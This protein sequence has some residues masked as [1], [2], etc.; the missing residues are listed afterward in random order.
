MATP[1]DLVTLAMLKAW[2]NIPAAS[3]DDA[4]LG[5]L[6]TQISRKMITQTN[7]NSLVPKA[8]TETLDGSGKT[9]LMLRNYPVTS[10]TSLAVDGV[11]IPLAPSVTSNG[12]VLEQPDQEPP[13]QRQTLSLRG[14]CF[15]RG[16]QNVSISYVAGYQ[17][18]AEAAVA[19]A[20]VVAQQ[21]YGHWVSDLGV[22]N[23]ATGAALTKVATGTAPLSGQYALTDQTKTQ[24]GYVFAAGDAGL[25]VLLSY[26]FVPAD[27]AQAAMEWAA[28]RYKYRDRIGMQSKSLGGQETTS[29][30]ISDTPKFIKDA[31]QQYTCVTQF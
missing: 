6:I 15:N 5:V 4:A 17:V 27:L 23:A 19:A 2:L 12:Y 26:G 13:G 22:K 20:T 16:V 7:R 11:S 30:A 25:A 9:A 29:F 24:G 31:V 3:A 28:E 8:F 1:S 18:A 21:P 14:S 10:L